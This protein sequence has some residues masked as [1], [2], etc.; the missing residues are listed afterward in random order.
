MTRKFVLIIIIIASLLAIVPQSCENNNEF[1]LYGNQECDTT[2][3]S[4]NSNIALILKEKC[5]RCHNEELSGNEVRHDSYASE[6][7]VINDGRLKTVINSTDPSIRMPKNEP[8]LDSCKLKLI[9]KWLDNGA[10]ENLIP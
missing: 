6:L 9:N 8:A 2:K 3:I 4:W 5:V 7:I 10:P 1:D